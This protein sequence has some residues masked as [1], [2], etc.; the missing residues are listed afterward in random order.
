MK[1]R[2]K[3]RHQRLAYESSCVKRVWWEEQRHGQ[4]PFH[5]PPLGLGL[6][7]AQGAQPLRR[8]AERGEKGGGTTAAAAAAAA[9]RRRRGKGSGTG[10]PSE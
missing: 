6:T 7:A 8:M 3:G 5:A 9:A 4:Q 10:T 1:S 2:D